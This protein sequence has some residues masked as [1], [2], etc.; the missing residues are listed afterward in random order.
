MNR[1][2]YTT[3]HPDSP[4]RVRIA[5]DL[6]WIPVTHPA[7]DPEDRVLAMSEAIRHNRAT[8]DALRAFAGDLRDGAAAMC[9][10][11]WMKTFYGAAK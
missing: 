5:G 11:G 9:G 8:P 10:R 6:C 7:R 4:D 1:Q 2:R 3:T